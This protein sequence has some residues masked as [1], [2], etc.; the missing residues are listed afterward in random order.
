MKG[1]QAA[2]AVRVAVVAVFLLLLE[3]LC[4]SGVI[5]PL[6]M[7]PPSAML[8]SLCEML[9]AGDLTDD[10]VRTFG[11]VAVAFAAATVVGF[12]VGALVHALPRLRRALDPI[13]ASYYSVPFFVFY[14]LLVALLGLSV[15]P[16]IA[17]AFAFAAPAVVMSTLLGL[18]R[19]PPVLL[20]VARI[21]RLGPAS[22]VFHVVLPAALP[23]ILNGIKLALAYAFI[24]VIAGEFILSGGGLGYHIAYAYES[25]D[26]KTMYGLMLFVLVSAILL[27]GLLH[28]WEGRLL[29]R[30]QR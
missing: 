11:T 27:N 23:S 28:M 9:L 1:R 17:I 19:V 15:L 16:L 12:A 2:M 3:V 8:I 13:L 18:D 14:P 25:F 7:I 20:K 22:T 6:V 10:I 5:S 4:R 30:R 26:N 29:R 24:A 21:H